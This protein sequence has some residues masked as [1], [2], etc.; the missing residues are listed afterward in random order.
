MNSLVGVFHNW[1]TTTKYIYPSNY[2]SWQKWFYLYINKELRWPQFQ[3]SCCGYWEKT[4]YSN[5]SSPHYFG[6]PWLNSV[7]KSEAIFGNL[8]INL[9]K[10]EYKTKAELNCMSCWIHLKGKILW[11]NRNFSMMQYTFKFFH[12]FKAFPFFVL[13]QNIMTI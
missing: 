7:I 6:S 2:Y 8:E 13:M 11:S 3:Y 9:S 10:Y 5:L 12:Y 4:Y 1:N